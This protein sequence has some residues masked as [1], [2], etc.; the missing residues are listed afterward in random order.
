M[1]IVLKFLVTFSNFLTVTNTDILHIRQLQTRTLRTIFASSLPI[2][3]STMPMWSP[4]RKCNFLRTYIFGRRW[5]QAT[6]RFS[7]LTLRS[8][9]VG[10]GVTFLLTTPTEAIT[11]IAVTLN[12]HGLTSCRKSTIEWNPSLSRRTR[13]SAIGLWAM[14][15]SKKKSLSTALFQRWFSTYGTMCL[16]TSARVATPSLKTL[17]QNSTCSLISVESQR[18]M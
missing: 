16:K 14:A 6:N 7:R 18:S 17:S 2:R 9:V 1:A 3:T 8:S 13:N 15:Q 11:L 10:I 12:T 5:T 4:V